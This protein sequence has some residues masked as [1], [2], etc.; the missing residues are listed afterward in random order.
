MQSV[1]A[2]RHVVADLKRWIVCCFLQAVFDLP[3]R[4][5]AALSEDALDSAVSFYAEA[6]PL[7]KKYGHKVAFR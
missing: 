1:L 2:L 4:M 6:L 3:R 5:R 7:L